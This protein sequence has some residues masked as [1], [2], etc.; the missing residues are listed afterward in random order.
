M[1]ANRQETRKKGSAYQLLLIQ[2]SPLWEARMPEN[3][4]R[5]KPEWL[6]VLSTK[7]TFHL[8]LPTRLHLRLTL[9]LLLPWRLAIVTAQK[10][11]DL[12]KSTWGRNNRRVKADWHKRNNIC[13]AFS[14]FSSIYFWVASFECQIFSFYSVLG[15]RFLSSTCGSGWTF[16]HVII[17][18]QNFKE[19]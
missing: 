1:L 5:K 6:M 7:S 8:L 16:W 13:L 19:S 15:I 17:Q 3:D 10:Q 9:L 2:H 4:T 14:H 18:S 11:A 12:P